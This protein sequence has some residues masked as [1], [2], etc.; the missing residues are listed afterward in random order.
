LKESQAPQPHPSLSQGA[1]LAVAE[2][3]GVS[4]LSTARFAFAASSFCKG[5]AVSNAVSLAFDQL[6]PAHLY[7]LDRFRPLTSTN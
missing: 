5:A 7:E 1:S 4:F 2:S 6:S 3:G